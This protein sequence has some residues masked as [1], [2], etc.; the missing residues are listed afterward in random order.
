MVVSRQALNSETALPVSERTRSRTTK[1]VS[2]HLH[3]TTECTISF[4]FQYGLSSASASAGRT[5]GDQLVT[6]MVDGQSAS[7][8]VSA[9]SGSR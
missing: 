5:F 7:L 4:A 2:G 3:Q 8:R 9:G 6:V 1:L